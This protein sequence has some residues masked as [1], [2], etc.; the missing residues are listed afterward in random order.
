MSAPS[1]GTSASPRTLTGAFV[2]ASL[3]LSGVMLQ[4][5]FRNPMASPVVI[6]ISTGGALGATS[7]IALG[8]GSRSPSGPFP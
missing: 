5:L 6:G 3:A 2:G 1:S 8:L 7:A 4:G